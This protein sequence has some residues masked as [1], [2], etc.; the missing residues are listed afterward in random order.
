MQQSNSHQYT[1]LK[2]DPVLRTCDLQPAAETPGGVL[3]DV[4]ISCW[5]GGNWSNQVR[6]QPTVPQTDISGFPQLAHGPQWGTAYPVQPGDWAKVDFLNGDQSAPI[7][8]AF[9]SQWAWW[10]VADVAREIGEPI[11]DRFD[12]LHPSGAWL[13]ILGDGSWVITT[14]GVDSPKCRIFISASGAVTLDAGSVTLNASSF[15]VNAGNIDLNGLTKI[16]GKEVTVIGGVDSAGH[17]IV[18]SGQ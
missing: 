17:P 16:S 4:P 13:R 6:H 8:T 1:V 9:T 14:P 15:E 12:L 10:G 3:W 5:W 11:E 7:I 18:N 2:Y